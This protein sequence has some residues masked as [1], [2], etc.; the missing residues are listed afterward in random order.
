M[1]IDSNT[2]GHTQWFNFTIKNGNKKRIK[3]N[4]CNFRKEK[5]LL[6]RVYSLVIG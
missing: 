4:I 6:Q 2:R 5:T 3:I 1:R